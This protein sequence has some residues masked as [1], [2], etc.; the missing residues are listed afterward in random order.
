MALSLPLTWRRA[1]LVAYR[2]TYD[3]P[4]II[5]PLRI[6]QQPTPDVIRRFTEPRVAVVVSGAVRPLGG[7]EGATS[8][9]GFVD[10]HTEVEGEMMCL[11]VKPSRRIPPVVRLPELRP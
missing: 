2:G 1:L 4:E 11:V 6:R 3:V 7:P 9:E 8:V 5:H 10:A